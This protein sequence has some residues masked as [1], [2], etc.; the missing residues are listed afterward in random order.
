MNILK[1][2]NDFSMQKLKEQIQKG[3]VVM[4]FF[5]P[6]CGHCKDMEPKWVEMIKK[7]KGK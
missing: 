5:A 6:W 7:L 2:T 4:K 1:V 3:G